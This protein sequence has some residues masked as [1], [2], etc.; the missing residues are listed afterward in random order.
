MKILDDDFI[1]SPVEGKIIYNG[2]I[3]NLN[4]KIMLNDFDLKHLFLNPYLELE[5]PFHIFGIKSN[6]QYIRSPYSGYLSLENRDNNNIYEYPYSYPKMNNGFENY[7]EKDIVDMSFLYSQKRIIY[8]IS[9]P[10][11]QINC[12]IIKFLRN[13]E[14]FPIEFKNKI[15]KQNHLINDEKGVNLFF[16]VIPV[17]NWNYK[18]WVKINKNVQ[19]EFC[20][21]FSIKQHL[22]EFID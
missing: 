12:Y 5:G 1:L 13:Q 16:V 3:N 21:K 2:Q 14:Q 6:N 18:T 4:S 19:P 10:K 17:K 7:L 22:I 11:N 20:K 8:K 15:V 9:S